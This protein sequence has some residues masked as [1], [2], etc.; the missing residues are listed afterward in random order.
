[1]NYIHFI[2]MMYTHHVNK[3]KQTFYWLPSFHLLPGGHFPLLYALSFERT[4]K[5]K[6]DAYFAMHVELLIL[7]S[8][9]M[10]RVQCIGPISFPCYS[11][12]NFLQLLIHSCICRPG[13]GRSE[14]W[15]ANQ[16]RRKV[17]KNIIEAF[18]FLFLILV[19]LL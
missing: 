3:Y 13:W 10:V 5:S 17:E 2:N 19:P 16:T 4:P 1:M 8:P 7:D 11:L 12:F 15:A 14:S 6:L 18:V 9:R